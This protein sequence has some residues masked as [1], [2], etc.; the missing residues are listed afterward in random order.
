MDLHVC[1][2]QG[3]RGEGGGGSSIAR[4]V[5]RELDE[6]GEKERE[7]GGGAE[8]EEEGER[9]RERGGGGGRLIEG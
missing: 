4:D 8:R 3:E 2:L 1:C 7:G 9:E 6:G 5:D